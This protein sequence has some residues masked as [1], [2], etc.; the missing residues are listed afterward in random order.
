MVENGIGALNGIMVLDLTR[1]LAGPFSTMWL[2]SMGAN[3]IKI[4]NPAEGDIT[5]SYG[6][7]VNDISAYFCTINRNKRAITLN[8][9]SEEG[10]E[11]F[12]KLVRKADIVIENFRPGVMDR[13]GLGYQ[14]LANINERII[15]AS[16]SGFGTYGPYAERPG[17]DTIAQGMSGI[18]YI[19]GQPDG[20][21]TRIGSS[22][23]DTVAGMNAV[24][25]ILAALHA[26]TAT[27][28]GQMVEVSLVDSL[29]SLSTQEYTQYFADGTVPSRMGNDYKRWA[30]YGAYAAKDG[31][32]IIGCGTER[33]FKIFAEQVLDKPLLIANKKFA[34]HS[35]RVVNR[36][37][38]NKI[39]NEWSKD[40]TVAEVC[41][42]LVKAD[43]PAGPVNSIKELDGDEHFAKIREMF[44]TMMQEG[45]GNL[46][47]TNIPVRFS[48]TKLVPMKS[49]PVTLGADNYDVFEEYL[50]LDS[51]EVDGL[52]KRAV[53]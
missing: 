12:L 13:L 29:I 49:A 23:G 17:Y 16:I 10:K 35:D 9:K 3:I 19:T 5:R 18:M 6:P 50:G 15:Y 52:K 26:R 4:E 36:K 28:R 44:I 11:I 24:I 1:V 30:P 43:I 33:H 25:G 51:S 41:S 45:I 21:P 42:V 27:G 38:L 46:T 40:K 14:K 53:V 31:Y 22:Y 47:V 8:L 7:F 39:I 32:F 20:P 48:D 37:E 2:A 34:T